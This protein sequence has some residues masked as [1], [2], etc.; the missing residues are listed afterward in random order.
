MITYLDTSFLIKAYVPEAESAQVASIIAGLQGD[1][2][3]SRLTDVEMAS[4]LHRRLSP[5][6]VSNIYRD[7]WQ[8]RGTNT[9]QELEIDT[10]VFELA[11]TLA[12]RHANQFQLR[13]LD[14]LHLAVALHHG[15]GTFA[16]Y[17]HR[18]ATAAVALGLQR[19]P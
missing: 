13:S 9:F 15:I 4:A 19:L 18:L 6:D 12:E 10:R 3:I 17:D 2:A 16:T 1:G 14:I 7:Y 5:Q 11:K 8:D